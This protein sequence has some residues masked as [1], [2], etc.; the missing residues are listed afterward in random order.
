MSD[1][2]EIP[3]PH[4]ASE[5]AQKAATAAQLVANAAKSLAIA[6]QTAATVA[7]EVATASQTLACDLDKAQAAIAR[8]KE[9]SDAVIEADKKL[10]EHALK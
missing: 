8:L 10:I 7:Q 3:P 4:D 5:E 1:V 6:T 2:P 9:C